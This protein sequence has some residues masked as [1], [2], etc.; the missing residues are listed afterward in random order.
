[1]PFSDCILSSIES[2]RLLS[3]G[4]NRQSSPFGDVLALIMRFLECEV[5]AYDSFSVIH[6]HLP[7]RDLGVIVLDASSYALC[8]Y[9]GTINGNVLNLFGGV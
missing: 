7:F 8:S 3:N 1:M 5:V 2:L 6:N 4:S 9:V